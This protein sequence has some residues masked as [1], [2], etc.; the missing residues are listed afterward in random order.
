EEE[1]AQASHA[2]RVAQLH[3]RL[4]DPHRVQMEEDVRQHYE[5]AVSVRCRP[6]VPEDRH[7]DLRLG[8]PVPE[9]FE[10]AFFGCNGFCIGHMPYDKLS[11]TEWFILFFTISE[12]PPDRSTA[13]ARTGSAGSCPR[14]SAHRRRARCA[15]A[16]ADAA[17]ALRN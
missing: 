15:R 14:G 6:S 1:E 11:T 5:H 4:P 17:W 8:Q 13:P 7:P 10:R 16:R 12:M 3:A 2:P 9:P